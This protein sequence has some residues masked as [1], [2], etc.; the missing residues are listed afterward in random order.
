MKKLLSVV[1]AVFI[2]PVCLLAADLHVSGSWEMT[3]DSPHGKITGPLLL[4][5]DGTTVTG[6]YETDHTGKV[7]V[8][9]KVEGERITFSMEVPAA[10]MTINFEGTKKGEMLSGTTTPL[11]GGWT[12]VQK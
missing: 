5:Q 11:G 8:N 10:Q 9:G 6:T 2:L 7:T 4:Q 1:F 12:A 3:V